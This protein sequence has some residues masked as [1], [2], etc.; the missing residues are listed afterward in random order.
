MMIITYFLLL[1]IDYWSFVHRF[2]MELR[3]QPSSFQHLPSSSWIWPVDIFYVSSFHISIVIIP[4]SR[5]SLSFS[6]SC[7]SRMM[8]NLHSLLLVPLVNQHVL[9]SSQRKAILKDRNREAFILMALMMV[10]SLQVAYYH[11]PSEL[12]LSVS[13]I[14]GDVKCK[15]IFRTLPVTNYLV[16]PQRGTVQPTQCL[17]SPANVSKLESLPLCSTFQFDNLVML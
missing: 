15:M 13:F 10:V 3:L 6:G 1:T 4:Y 16:A 5:E 9:S 14:S 2:I 8:E 12:T 11:Y 17:V 7:S